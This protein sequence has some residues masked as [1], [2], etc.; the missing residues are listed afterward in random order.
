[1]RTPIGFKVTDN[2]LAV[3][4]EQEH[5]IKEVM[6]EIDLERLE[7]VLRI[8]NEIGMSML[9]QSKSIARGDSFVE[10]SGRKLL[11]TL[12]KIYIKHFEPV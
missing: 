3:V 6:N 5:Q 9:K 8:A 4:N 7:A 10:I 2:K 11:K 12:D 1:M